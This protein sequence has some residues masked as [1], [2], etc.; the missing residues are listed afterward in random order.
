[1]Q[2]KNNPITIRQQ[3]ETYYSS[4]FNCAES[5]CKAI[6]DAYLEK[7]ATELS[8][9]ATY[10]GGGI[11]S[12]HDEACGAIT[13]GIVA[14]GYLFGRTEAGADI[15]ASKNL[16]AEFKT[17]FVKKNETAHCGSLIEGLEEDKRREKCQKLTGDAAELLA[18][19]LK[20]SVI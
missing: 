9:A 19:L 4:G 7:N 20:N 14:L 13:G 2:E 6:L 1:M 3:A 16:A 17:L 10:F 12:S 18:T 15:E 8:T 5:V 11:A